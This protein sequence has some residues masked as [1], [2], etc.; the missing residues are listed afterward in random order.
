[1]DYTR[2]IGLL[3]PKQ[4]KNKSITLIGVGATGSYVALLLAQMGPIRFM[5]QA[6]SESSKPKPSRI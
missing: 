1:M 4:I 2:Q 5:N 6:I 3:D